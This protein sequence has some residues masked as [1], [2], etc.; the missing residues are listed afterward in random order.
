MLQKSV[1]DEVLMVKGKDF[2]LKYLSTQ[3]KFT[4][5]DAKSFFSWYTIQKTV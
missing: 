5:Y 3:N 4:N 1:I 2:Y